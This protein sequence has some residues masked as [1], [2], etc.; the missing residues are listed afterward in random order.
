MVMRADQKFKNNVNIFV[1]TLSGNNVRYYVND[2][3]KNLKAKILDKEGISAYKQ[4]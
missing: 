3:I 4:F 1:K 2:Y